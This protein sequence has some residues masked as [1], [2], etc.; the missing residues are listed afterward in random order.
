MPADPLSSPDPPRLSNRVHFADD[1]RSSQGNI[2]GYAVC[3]RIAHRIAVVN[4]P[5][6]DGNT[7]ELSTQIFTMRS[8]THANE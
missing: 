3:I 2:C 8:R 4:D 1:T 6:L 7:A 5:S